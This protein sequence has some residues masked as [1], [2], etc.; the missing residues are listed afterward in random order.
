MHMVKIKHGA[1]RGINK[2]NENDELARAINGYKA[3]GISESYRW[4]EDE[5]KAHGWIF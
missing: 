3:M 1:T 2:S 5:S 4:P